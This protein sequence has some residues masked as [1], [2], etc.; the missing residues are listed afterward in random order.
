M[1]EMLYDVFFSIQEDYE[2]QDDLSRCALKVMEGVKRLERNA[3]THHS[4]KD[5]ID[6]AMPAST[7]IANQK[8]KLFGLNFQNVFDI[9]LKQSVGSQMGY[10]GNQVLQFND[11]PPNLPTAER[12]RLI[13]QK[14]MDQIKK[15]LLGD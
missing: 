12:R 15:E 14:I 3:Q 8:T 7:K 6:G 13:V 2:T 11:I 9:V 5:Y 1:E 10:D 4:V